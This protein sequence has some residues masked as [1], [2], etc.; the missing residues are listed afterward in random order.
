MSARVGA[1]LTA[2]ML[3]CACSPHF[4]AAYDARLDRALTSLGDHVDLLFTDLQRTAGT[5]SGTWEPF[6]PRY[7]SVRGEIAELAALASARP[8]NQLT[9]RA[10]ELLDSNVGEVEKAHRE[11]LT[12]NEIGILR[13]LLGQQVRA[14]RQLETA[15]PKLL[16]K[17]EVSR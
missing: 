12:A 4:I 6:V 2:V 10:L 9:L 8:N 14:L 13:D 15:K 16:L 5:E 3:V 17:A 1:V 7:A 11:G